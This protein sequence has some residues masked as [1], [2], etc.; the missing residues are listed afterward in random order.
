MD[1]FPNKLV[2]GVSVQDIA[3]DFEDY[4]GDDFYNLDIKKQEKIITNIGRYIQGQLQTCDGLDW[5][6]T[7]EESCGRVVMELSDEV[8]QV[9]GENGAERFIE[10]RDQYNDGWDF[11]GKGKK[12]RLSSV[13][14]LN[15]FICIFK[16]STGPSLFLS[17][18]GNLALE[19]EEEPLY[20]SVEFKRYGFICKDRE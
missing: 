6:D 9:I 7:Y 3:D 14:S 17:K 12:L 20:V 13:D 5:D 1:I 10:F 11:D 19:W 4:T 2:F 16:F 8:L 18:N 15:K